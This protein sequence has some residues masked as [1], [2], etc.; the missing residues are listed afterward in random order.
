MK[1]RELRPISAIRVKPDIL[2]E[3]RVAAVI[4]KKTLGQWLENAILEKIEREKKSNQEEQ[5]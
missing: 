4:Q 5:A 3:A 2:H 1:S